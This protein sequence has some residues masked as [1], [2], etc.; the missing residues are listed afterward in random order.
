MEGM[1]CILCFERKY[2]CRYVHS[3]IHIYVCAQTRVWVGL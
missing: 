3:H 2:I 1:T